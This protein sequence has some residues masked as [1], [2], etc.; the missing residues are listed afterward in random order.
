MPID[1]EAGFKI[2]RNHHGR[3][4]AEH[5][6]AREALPDG[7]KTNWGS[8]PAFFTRVKAS[9]VAAILSPAIIWFHY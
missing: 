7:F 9:A 1:P 4:G 5:R 3:L 6:G 2:A 8:T